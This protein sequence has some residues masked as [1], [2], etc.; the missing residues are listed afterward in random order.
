MVA[1]WRIATDTPMYLAD[2]LSGRGAETTGGRWNQ[3]GTPMLYASSTRALACLETLVHLAGS[4]PLPLNRYLVELAFSE[5]IWKKRTILDSATHVGWDAEP[6][7]KIS[8]EWGDEWAR[9]KVSLLAEVP[10]VIVPEE[11]NILVNP[12][13]ADIFKISTKKQRRWSYD[14]R[15]G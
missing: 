6:A 1:V 11:A 3:K 14:M 10:S 2:D 4:D 13:H 12:S 9:S 15:L 5:E 7:G 8:L